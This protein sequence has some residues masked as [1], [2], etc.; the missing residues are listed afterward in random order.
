MEFHVDFHKIW[1]ERCAATRTIRERFGVKN[2]L[3]YLV[4]E[5]LLNF[6]K[7]ADQDP[8]FAA[9]LPLTCDSGQAYPPALQMNEK[10]HVVRNQPS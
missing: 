6:A 2:A 3:D 7:A 9:E 10:Q 5:K 1:E 4:G 8:G